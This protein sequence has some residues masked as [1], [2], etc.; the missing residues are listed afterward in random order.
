MVA[1]PADDQDPRQ[2]FGDFGMMLDSNTDY[3]VMELDTAGNITR[4]S[5][6]AEALLGYTEDEVVGR[7]RRCSMSR[8]IAPAIS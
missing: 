2:Y 1:R 5:A 8:R 3:G 7:K 4:W 6:G